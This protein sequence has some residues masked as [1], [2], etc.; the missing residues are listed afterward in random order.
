[1][2]KRKKK[3]DTKRVKISEKF[4]WAFYPPEEREGD[5]HFLACAKVSGATNI[6]FQSVGWQGRAGHACCVVVVKK[7]L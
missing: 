7:P 6:I 4:I 3:T 1:V 2:S 5:G